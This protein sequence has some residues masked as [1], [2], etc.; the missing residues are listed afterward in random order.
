MQGGVQWSLDERDALPFQ[1]ILSNVTHIFCRRL[2]AEMGDAFYSRSTQA[3]FQ[4]KPSGPARLFVIHG[5]ADIMRVH[6]FCSK[7]W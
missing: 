7:H 5:L 2:I 4:S 6:V 3:F 1:C